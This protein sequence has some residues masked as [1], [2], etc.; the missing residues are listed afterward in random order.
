MQSAQTQIRL[1]NTTTSTHAIDLYHNDGTTD[2]LIDKAT[3]PRGSGVSRVLY[4]A[5][6][7]TLND[8]HSLKI[9][10]DNASA[11]NISV[12]GREVEV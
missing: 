4:E 11:F 7:L 12:S 2:F 3:L 1:T 6:N 5:Q 10:S 9:Q 8:G